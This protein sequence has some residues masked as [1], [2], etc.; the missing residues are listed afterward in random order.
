MDFVV[1]AM[2][3]LRDEQELDPNTADTLLAIEFLLEW[4]E[5]DKRE[6]PRN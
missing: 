5:R 6:Y 4:L 2:V 1:S 3:A